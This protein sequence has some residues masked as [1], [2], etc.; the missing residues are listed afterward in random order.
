MKIN[1][2]K[3]KKFKNITKKF[4]LAGTLAAVLISS[5]TFIA[6]A[7]TI[8][9]IETKPSYYNLSQ[10]GSYLYIEGDIDL[11]IIEKTPNLNEL[12]I[13]G[14]NV[15]NIDCL[16]NTNITNLTF[17]ECN[18]GNEKLTM[19]QNVES[20]YFSNCIL[21]DLSNI[22]PSNS[23]TSLSFVDCILGSI[24]GIEKLNSLEKLSFCSVGIENIDELKYLDNLHHLTLAYTCV[25]DLS[26][27]KNLDLYFLNVSNTLT[28]DSFEA[29]KSL[30]ELTEFYTRNCEMQYTKDI[31]DYTTKNNI[32]T[33]I[34]E[35]GLKIKNE[36]L[37][38]K[39]KIINDS[40]SDNEKVKVIVDY[41]VN[42]IS[43]DWRVEY[44]EEL[45]T[46]YNDEALK[47]A[48]EG[49]GC[50]RNYTA[51]TTALLQACNINAYETLGNNHI[52]NVVEVDGEYY[53]LDTTNV[54][55]DNYDDITHS[56]NYM[57]TADEFGIINT[58]AYIPSS[59]Y[60]KLKNHDLSNDAK[61]EILIEEQTTKEKIELEEQT[62][63]EKDYLIEETTS[64]IEIEQ[65]TQNVN[66][67][68]ETKEQID[69]ESIFKNLQA[70][71]ASVG[72]IVGIAVALG[73]AFAINKKGKLAK[74]KD[75]ENKSYLKK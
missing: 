51:L 11:S 26:P 27:I 23:L 54:Y 43:Y 70:K 12:Y 1:K 9:E 25:N 48:L 36:V 18:F 64:I 60:N 52:W 49:I 57:V 72:A 61:E 68:T 73:S 62:T 31:I 10:D 5:P 6:N 34:T 3:I 47:Y 7:K 19:P 13:N 56:Q 17:V 21:D 75:I 44:D 50:C 71:K 14:S 67:T 22:S 46:Q 38:I 40:M 41:V 28:I 74:Q 69:K 58:S 29:V 42:N 35:D 32:E 24:K 39:N 8:S 59:Y 2:E 33:D 55:T 65:E 66:N 20:I 37:N 4:V 45:S 53:W 63:E 30:N 15:S 16:K